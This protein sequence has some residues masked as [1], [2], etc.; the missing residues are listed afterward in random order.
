MKQQM[1]IVVDGNCG[2]GKNSFIK[3][4]QKKLN[5]L[6]IDCEVALEPVESWNME[7]LLENAAKFPSVYMFQLQ[8]LIMC[9]LFQRQRDPNKSRV[10]IFERSLETS[11]E[12]FV[13]LHTQNKN[14]SELEGKI[15]HELYQ[16]FQKLKK[17]PKPDLHFYLKC[18]PEECYQRVQK[19]NQP[20]D[21]ALTLDYIKKLDY[22]YEKYFDEHLIKNKNLIVFDSSSCDAEKLA[23]EATR[24][25]CLRLSM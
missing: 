24:Y 13:K 7:Q 9:T 4:I 23:E 12:V 19:R 14:L 3:L 18:T 2:S 20:G 22:Q 25:I 5:T 11:F 1:K 6:N 15:L 10:T 17:M 16:T 8:T 21:R